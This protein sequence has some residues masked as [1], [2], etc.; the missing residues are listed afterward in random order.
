MAR[1]RN[2]KHNKQPVPANNQSK[3]T[4]QVV[5]TESF[6]GPIPPPD[7]L[8]RYEQMVPGAAD[9][10]IAMAE[11]ES[12]HRRELESRSLV[13]DITNRES[14]VTESRLGQCFAFLF[15]LFTVG[16]GTYA[17]VHGAEIAGG[18][19]GVGGLGSII[20]AFIVGRSK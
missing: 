20:T 17:A 3:Q 10:I 4:T 11:N 16:C 7:T 2:R 14:T 19:I 12:D 15:G 6:S 5:R 18:L 1:Q 9:R 8:A 13:A